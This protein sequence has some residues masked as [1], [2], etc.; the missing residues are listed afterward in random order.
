MEENW[1]EG[2]MESTICGFC[3]SMFLATF[4]CCTVTVEKGIEDGEDV[5]K[6]R[7]GGLL[8]AVVDSET[9]SV[10]SKLLVDGRDCDIYTCPPL[11]E[12][13]LYQ[14][15]KA[16]IV[17]G[18]FSLRSTGEPFVPPTIALFGHPTDY[19]GNIVPF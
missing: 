1:R 14:P 9:S 12:I 13:E 7:E 19:H 8:P 5:T 4:N 2:F 15:N 11:K 3:P 10:E 6:L 18:Y 16:K 17:R